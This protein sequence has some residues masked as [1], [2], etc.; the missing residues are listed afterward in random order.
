MISLTLLYTRCYLFTL[1][2]TEIETIFVLNSFIV[3]TRT[4]RVQKEHVSCC[5]DVCIKLRKFVSPIQINAIWKST[6]FHGFTLA[7]YRFE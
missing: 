5:L 1:T 6:F 4:R 3:W 2:K 7:A